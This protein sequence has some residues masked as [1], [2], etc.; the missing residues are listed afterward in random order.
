VHNENLDEVLRVYSDV[1]V[2]ID[3]NRSVEEVAADV[4]NAIESAT[5]ETLSSA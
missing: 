1:L 5:S 3:G 2:R 4:N